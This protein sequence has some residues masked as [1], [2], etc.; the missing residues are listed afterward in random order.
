MNSVLAISKPHQ[1]GD[2][3]QIPKKPQ[4]SYVSSSGNSSASVA[5]GYGQVLANDLI[6]KKFS[7]M[8][9]FKEQAKNLNQIWTDFQAS[10]FPKP[11]ISEDE[12]K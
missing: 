9:T 1:L 3:T 12:F 11:E 7:V 10:L 5:V 4:P 2:C 8:E 6:E